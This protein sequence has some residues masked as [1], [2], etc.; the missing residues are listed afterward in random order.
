M[1]CSVAYILWC[2][3]LPFIRHRITSSLV[4]QQEG[5]LTFYIW[6]HI[7]KIRGEQSFHNE[8]NVPADSSISPC[9]GFPTDM[10]E[11]GVLNPNSSRC[12]R[13]LVYLD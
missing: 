1:M 10:N 8:P 12:I 13:H 3:D 2:E 11:V 9:A 5:Q 7:F 4:S 6:G